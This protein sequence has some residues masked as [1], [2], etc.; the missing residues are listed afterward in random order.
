MCHIHLKELN[1]HQSFQ[2]SIKFISFRWGTAPIRRWKTR[3]TGNDQ[4]SRDFSLGYK[5][6]VDLILRLMVDGLVFDIDSYSIDEMMDQ[7][8]RVC[9]YETDLEFLS[10]RNFSCN[11]RWWWWWLKFITSLIIASSPSIW[12]CPLVLGTLEMPNSWFS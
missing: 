5:M 9:K 11:G 8:T 3:V 12:T 1:F 2:V 7:Y 10:W 4:C 6:M